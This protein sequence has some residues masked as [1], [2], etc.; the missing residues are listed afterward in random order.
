M[1]AEPLPQSLPITR[2]IAWAGDLAAAC[3]V[4][5][6]L[7]FGEVRVESTGVLPSDGT[8]QLGTDARDR[9]QLKPT[10]SL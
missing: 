5:I 10:K 2:I 3:Q 7:G 9:L 4:Q 1:V 6:F 8:I